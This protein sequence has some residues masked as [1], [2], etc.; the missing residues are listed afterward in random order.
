MAKILPFR[1]V[2]YSPERF[3]R[4]LTQLVTQPYDKITPEMQE[5]YYNR[6]PRNFIRI[7]LGKRYSSDD[8][9]YN[10]YLRA[11]GYL[12]WWLEDGTFVCAQRPA[13]Y[14]YHQVFE[15]DGRSVVRRGFV[16]LAE[17]EPPGKGVKAH[18][19]TL[20]GPK[21]D[22]LNLMRH[23]RAQVG[24][25]FMLY[26]DPERVA[27]EAIEKAIEGREPDFVA[28]DWFGN[29]HRLWAIYDEDVIAAVRDALCDKTLFIA[30]GH[31]RYETAVNYWRECEEKGLVPEPGAT[32]TFRNR[33]MTF[34]NM[35]DPGLVI[36][37]THR[38][39]HSVQGFDLAGLL[40]GIR[41]NF[42]VEEYPILTEGC[43]R[44]RFQ[45]AMARME[46]LGAQGKHA[47]VLVPKEAK[48]YYLLVLKDER[49]MDEAIKEPV[50]SD[51]KRL[52][53]SIL[54]KLILEDLLGIDAK[55][56]EEKRNLYYIRER[57]KGF[58]YLE[59]DPKVQCVFYMNPTKIEEVRRI[60]EAGERMPQKSTDFYPK[61]L[62]GMVFNR[63]RFAE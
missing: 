54:H 62:T 34:V 31:H 22:R 46:A 8:E 15:V 45:E 2:T 37:P 44:G 10:Y 21:A 13:I 12:Q 52:D 51:W 43:V 7:V 53:V 36:L 56:L 26:D 42:D 58:E 57:E 38:V 55:A 23:I 47:F 4:D 3:G 48:A 5:E 27:D 63:L 50:S 16:A 40:E 9:Y 32:E 35:S 6:H 14:A 28:K 39:V 33:M 1:G 20:A 18:E 59:K 17:L 60:A 49:I 29:E 19:K 25:I 41:Q 61:L 30:D 24:H 11:A